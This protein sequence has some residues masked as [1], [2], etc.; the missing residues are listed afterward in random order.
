MKKII[1]LIIVVST[2][3]TSC[4]SDFD[5]NAPYKETM[6]VYGFLN[7]ADT[8]AQYIRISKAFLGEGNALIMAQQPDSINYADILD[9]KLEEI[10]NGSSINTYQLERVDSIPKD[11]GLFAY[12][13]QVYYLLKNQRVN[14]TS[15]YRLTI[16]NTQTGNTASSLTR[17][18]KD[19]N[20][21][22]DIDNP[23]AADADFAPANM[24]S[25][26]F[27]PVSNG[28]VYDVV[29]RFHY[30]EDSAG[31][32]SYHFVD[33]NFPDQFVSS[34]NDIIF[35]YYRPDF[36]RLL[37]NSIPFKS[38]VTRVP[39]N[40]SLGYPPMEFQILAGTEDFHTY[41]ELNSS[42]NTSLQD[43][44]L[45]TTVE[46][47]VGLFTSRL[48]HIERRNLTQRSIDTLFEGHLTK[49]LF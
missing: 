17:I 36:Y 22:I 44:P 21:S 8:I 16:R 3:F 33:W 9:V 34:T 7:S 32:L 43:P 5:L 38:G 10:L 4:K 2:V 20:S 13:Y 42:S 40:S 30:T 19:L 47:G 12:P 14:S 6:V 48:I 35:P 11:A 26:K 24:F 28:K 46:N 45:F 23:S 27:R 39:G 31:I 37:A 25:V 1:L 18:V 29:I 41:L 49:D 15:M